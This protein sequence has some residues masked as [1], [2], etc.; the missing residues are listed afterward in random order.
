MTAASA[1]SPRC[2]R[3]GCIPPW[4][5]RTERH[6]GPITCSETARGRIWGLRPPPDPRRPETIGRFKANFAPPR[7]AFAEPVQGQDLAGLVRRGKVRRR[8]AVAELLG[9]DPEPRAEV[10]G[11]GG[12]AQDGLRGP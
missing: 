8:D 12:F 10:S 11:P 1:S 9:S 5:P 2:L 3:S 7:A 4:T 6:P